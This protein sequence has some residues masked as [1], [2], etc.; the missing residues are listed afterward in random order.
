MSNI[1]DG[2]AIAAEIRKEIAASISELAGKPKL[3][4]Y[5]VG[6]DA[7]SVTYAKSL[8]KSAE[9]LG[10]D[11]EYLRE[12]DSVRWTTIMATMLTMSESS[13]IH[14][15]LL[16]R[17]VPKPHKENAIVE[18]ILPQKDIDCASPH[19]MGLL[20]TGHPKMLPPTPAACV[21]ILKRSGVDT[22]GKIV[23]IVGRSNV[24]G[25]PLALMLARK[26]D[27]D[28]TVVLCHSRTRDLTGALKNA[29][30]VI[31]A[32]GVPR[33]ITAEM[34][35]EGAVV[36]DAGINWTDSG[37]AGD[38]DFENVREKVSMIT[39]VPGGVGPV[40]RVMLFRNLLHAYKI[41]RL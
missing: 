21:E 22:S 36:I 17:P 4:I 12:V 18:M 24:V 7:S 2:K 39:P 3:V 31:A 38:V 11:C 6:D 9:K 13:D 20:A 1:I 41:Q 40:T 32:V 14:G 37:M 10:I 5:Q 8:A 15:I 19:S 35:P 25:K 30:I 33:L 26:G 16:M 34:I 27:G 29:E 23:G 28:A